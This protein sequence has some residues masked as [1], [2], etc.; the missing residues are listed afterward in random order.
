MRKQFEF[1]GYCSPTS[2]NYY[3]DGNRYFI[4]EDFRTVARF[5]EYKNAGFTV[6][7]LQHENSYD[8]EDFETSACN[9]CMTNAVKAGIDKIIVS[10]ARL[11]KL[12]EE[13]TLVA[14]DGKFKSEKELIDFIDFCTKPYRNKEGF[15]GIQLFDEPSYKLFKSYGQV[16]KAIKNVVPN[17]FL[18]CNLLNIVEKERLSDKDETL[19]SAYESYLNGFLDESGAD[20][21]MYDDYPFRRD[22]LICGHSLP[23]YQICAK[24]CRER[25]KE[26]HHVMQSFSWFT[27]GRLVMRRVTERDVRWQANMAMGFGVKE[28][29][30]FT[31]FTKPMLTLKNGFGSDGIDGTAMINRDGSRTKLYY[32]IKKIISEMKAFAPIILEYDY[33]NNYIFTEKGKT[34]KNFE[35]TEFAF[36]N[37]GCGI[38]VSPDKGVTLVTEHEGKDGKSI[39]YMIENIGNIK[40]E[41]FNG[42]KPQKVKIDGIG[43]GA[44][45]YSRGKLLSKKPIDGKFI[46]TL[47]IGEAIFIEIKK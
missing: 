38:K 8:G 44:N 7:L 24:I 33:K 21:V 22:Y 41:Y 18:Q 11:K 42:A 16:V 4:G 20:Y 27:C 15:Y 45:I 3:I 34:A 37:D 39:L 32:A 46:A 31:Y 13:K 1:Y 12:C 5:K 29:A 30:F 43:D 19:F 26:F 10:D 9:L 36:L 25:K 6:L 28:F 40:E 14:D 47:P 35:A 17:A 2:G 23:N